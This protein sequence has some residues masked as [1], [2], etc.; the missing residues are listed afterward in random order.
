MLFLIGF[1]IVGG[2]FGAFLISNPK[3]VVMG[4]IR[5]RQAQGAKPARSKAAPKVNLVL[6][7]KKKVLKPILPKPAIE[8]TEGESV[9]G[10][11]AIR[12]KPL[13]DSKTQ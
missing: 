6:E 10:L 9:P 1:L 12:R 3:T 5:Q 13:E 7:P 4:V 2:A 11:D 8:S